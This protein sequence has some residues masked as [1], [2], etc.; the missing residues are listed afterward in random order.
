[1]HD[2][3]YNTVCIFSF[4]CSIFLL[5]FYTTPEIPFLFNMILLLFI[6]CTIPHY[7]VRFP[8]CAVEV[9]YTLVAPARPLFQFVHQQ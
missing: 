1:M 7:C 5:V 8:I 4:F 3:R 9:V 6:Y 2:K